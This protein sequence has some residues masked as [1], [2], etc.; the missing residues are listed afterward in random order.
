MRKLLCWLALFPSLACAQS[1]LLLLNALV[2]C[3]SPGNYLLMSV[4]GTM[5]CVALPAG[6]TVSGNPP[7]LSLP[8]PPPTAP[9]I[10][11]ETISL[12][13]LPSTSSMV[14]YTPAHTPIGGVIL[15]WYQSSTIALTNSGAL[16]WAGAPLNITLPQNWQ[17]TDSVVI[18]YRW[19]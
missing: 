6:A 11:L 8:S 10:A 16:N 14:S 12:A 19:Q 13:S 18:V 5:A 3:P 2:R 4:N 17:N 15:Y 1:S 7:A 9:Q